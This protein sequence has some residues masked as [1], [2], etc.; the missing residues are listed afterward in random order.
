M[1][2]WPLVIFSTFLWCWRRIRASLYTSHVLLSCEPLGAGSC[3]DCLL[4]TPN[5]RNIKVDRIRTEL[6]RLPCSLPGLSRLLHVR[7][8]AVDRLDD[9]PAF[10]GHHFRQAGALVRLDVRR[11]RWLL[12]PLVRTSIPDPV[13]RKR[14]EVALWVFI[15]YFPACLLA[16]HDLTPFT[17][18]SAVLQSHPRLSTRKSCKRMK[19]AQRVYF[20]LGFPGASTISMVRPS[21]A[22]ACSTIAT[23]ASSSA[24]S[25]RSAR[26]ISG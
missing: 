21:R 2:N 1:P 17:Q 20:L 15:L 4:Q 10:D 19:S 24:T 11:R 26:A 9:P 7:G 13:R 6:Q 8:Q 5:S 3:F 25:F 16:W 12:P 23:S 14:L 18:N 22:G